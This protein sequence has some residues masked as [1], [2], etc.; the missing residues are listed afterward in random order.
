MKTLKFGQEKRVMKHH[1]VTDLISGYMEHEMVQVKENIFFTFQ[2][3]LAHLGKFWILFLLSLEILQI[4]MIGQEIKIFHIYP[5]GFW[6][7]VRGQEK[8]LGDKQLN[9]GIHLPV[10]SNCED[11]FRIIRKDI[12]NE[13]PN[14]LSL[15]GGGSHI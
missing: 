7:G 13:M 9:E 2:L 15:V 3:W 10:C 4:G 6:V 14:T 11:Q 1:I 5:D 8:D 12:E